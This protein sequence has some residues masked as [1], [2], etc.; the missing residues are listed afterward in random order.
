MKSE[1]KSSR[2]MK[3]LAYL[4]ENENR[5][6]TVHC[7]KKEDVRLCMDALLR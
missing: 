5:S 7:M 6:W 3:V 2:H 4:P 1:G